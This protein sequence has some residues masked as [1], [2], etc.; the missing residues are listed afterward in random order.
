MVVLTIAL[1]TA[2]FA[3]HNGLYELVIN[4]ELNSLEM[5]YGLFLKKISFVVDPLLLFF[6]SLIGLTVES[7]IITY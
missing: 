5:I 6:F 1:I 2:R 3:S 7:T 4:N